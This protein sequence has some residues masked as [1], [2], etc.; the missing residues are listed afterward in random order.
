M[1]P[2]LTGLF[3]ALV[4]SAT[5]PAHATQIDIEQVTSPG[6]IE[7]WLVEDHT[8]P[9]VAIEI[10]FSGGAS[11]DA[12]G[13]R[14]ATYLMTGLL[15][16]GA[17]DMD[18]TAFA[19]A[20]EGMAASFSFDVFRDDLTVSA[21]MLTENRDAAADLLRAA[22]V[23]PRFDEDAIERVRGQVLSIIEGNSRDPDDIAAAT[24]NA[25]AFG[26]HPYGTSLEG[27]EDSVSALTRA[28]IVAAHRA[29]LTRDRVVVG[30]AGDITAEELGP[31][32]DHLLGDL[33]E[34]GAEMPAPSEWQ[35][36]GG[37]T[38]VDFP[39]PQSVAIF[40]HEGIARDDPDFFPAFVLN[41]ILG[42][43]GFQS[44]LMR[45]V[46]VDRGLT[47]GIASFLS[48]A[49]YGPR[50][51]GQ[52][53]SSNDLVAE[54]I[55]VT[56][57]QWADLAENG[58]TAE[59]LEAAQRY[60]T[61]AYPLRFDGNGRIA[62]ILAS[63]QADDM[64]LDYIA[65]RNDRVNAVTRDDIRRVAARVLRPEDLH[66]VVVGRPEGLETTQ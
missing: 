11:L 56:R 35:A 1:I 14:G 2:R 36:E 45:E 48:L 26:D 61:G 32:I 3:A 52:F 59:E 38:V 39:S 10:W 9:F 23:E 40:G 31:L 51:A 54:A 8:N 43:G 55:E 60:L 46:R 33:P 63:M 6:G 57:A 34:T 7:A 41:Q 44:R 50:I 4:L 64:P 21:L 42:G 15:E 66:F 58:V 53:S 27:T 28:D 18:A 22:L 17:G 30:A 47:Y 65:T 24:F 12:E 19:Q 25:L 37:V 16:E 49:D 29:V 20:A 62:G 5:G 13:K